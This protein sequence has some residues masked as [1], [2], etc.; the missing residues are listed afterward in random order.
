ML[1]NVG[2][3]DVGEQESGQDEEEIDADIS[4]T[5]SD[6]AAVKKTAK[7]DS[8]STDA[9]E[10]WPVGPGWL[11]LTTMDARRTSRGIRRWSPLSTITQTSY[12]PEGGQI[13]ASQ[14]A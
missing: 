1:F 4:A 14:Q 12:V 8:D 11:R 13:R 10:L 3:D 2:E 9:V 7:I 5:E 6:D